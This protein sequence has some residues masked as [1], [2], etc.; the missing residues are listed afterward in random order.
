MSRDLRSRTGRGRDACVAE[1]PPPP[2]PRA[3]RVEVMLLPQVVV[4]RIALNALDELIIPD[5]GCSKTIILFPTCLFSPN[6]TTGD[7]PTIFG[8]A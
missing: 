4:D 2:P 8:L 3:E 5:A 1:R 6:T 7:G